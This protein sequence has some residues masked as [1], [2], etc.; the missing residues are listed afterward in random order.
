VTILLLVH[1]PA[2]AVVHFSLGHAAWHGVVALW[3]QHML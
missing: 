2:L 3:N 1:F